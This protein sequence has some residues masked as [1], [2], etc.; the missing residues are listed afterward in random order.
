MLRSAIAIAVLVLL[1]CSSGCDESAQ[2]KTQY[3]K[4]PAQPKVP[5][6]MTF[7]VC[8]GNSGILNTNQVLLKLA[9]KKDGRFADFGSDP[10]YDGQAFEIEKNRYIEKRPDP[11]PETKQ[12]F[13]RHMRSLEGLEADLNE[14]SSGSVAEIGSDELSLPIGRLGNDLLGPIWSLDRETLEL[15]FVWRTDGDYFKGTAQC[16]VTNKELWLA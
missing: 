6:T 2:R 15:S 16:S 1:A 4:T 5:P 7:F 9:K 3:E 12:E 10:V 8:D 13:D 14:G 11:L